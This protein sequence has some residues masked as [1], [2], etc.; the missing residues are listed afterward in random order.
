MYMVS[1]KSYYCHALN[2]ISQFIIC[3][4]I[5]YIRKDIHRPAVVSKKFLSKVYHFFVLLIIVDIYLWFYCRAYYYLEYIV[6]LYLIIK[7]LFLD[8]FLLSVCS[9]YRNA[10]YIFH[11]DYPNTCSC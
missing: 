10:Y 6:Q 8:Q 3:T 1:G 4:R 2:C 9:G 7:Y 11:A 5:L